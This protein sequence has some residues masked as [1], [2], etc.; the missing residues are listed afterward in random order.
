MT[1][2]TDTPTWVAATRIHMAVLRNTEASFE[3]LRAAEEELLRMAAI[4]D[5]ALA[6][7]KHGRITP[8]EHEKNEWARMANYAY[9]NE[10]NDI[11]HK[12]SMAA[13]LCKGEDCSV[14]WFDGLQNTYR[15]WL[16]D[17]LSAV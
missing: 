12:F 10:R 9:A 14:A 4:V 7:A 13:T 8:S 2:E 15:K 16:V 17:G 5:R 6:A 11:G 1:Y 3:G